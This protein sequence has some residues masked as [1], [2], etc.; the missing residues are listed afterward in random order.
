MPITSEQIKELRGK[1]GVSIMACKKAL[2]SANGDMEKAI[3]IL[4]KEGARVADK[5]AERVLKAGIVESYIHATKQVGV[6]LEVRCETDF[7]AKNE[8]FQEFTHDVAMHIAATNPLYVSED[9][10]PT[11]TKDGIKKLFEEEVGKLDKPEE[12]KAKILEGKINTYIKENALL[13]QAY[14]KDPSITIGGYLQSVIQKFGENT[15]I[16]RFVR[17]NV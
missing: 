7:V 1:T 5:K 9:D 15:E 3:L 2:E 16:S 14:V 17:Y 4:R 6:M 12:V 8:G 11:E 10:I 13:E